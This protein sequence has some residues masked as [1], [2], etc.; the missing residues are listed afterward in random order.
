MT[1]HITCVETSGRIT[2]TY[3]PTARQRLDK[4]G[5][6]KTN[7]LKS[8]RKIIP[9]YLQLLASGITMSRNE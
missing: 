7:Q 8:L 5:A 4:H 2:V 3:R 9:K 6:A 1:V